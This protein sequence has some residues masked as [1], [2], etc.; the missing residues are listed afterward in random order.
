MECYKKIQGINFN[1]EEY[2]NIVNLV[3]NGKNYLLTYRRIY[4]LTY[5]SKK[6]CIKSEMIATKKNGLPYMKRG[7]FA[8]YN[9]NY[10]ND[11]LNIC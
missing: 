7:R 8:L 4:K 10:I 9:E 3:L 1:Q 6:D 2:K 5:N 11:L